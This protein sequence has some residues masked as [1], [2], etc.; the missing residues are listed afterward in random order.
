MKMDVA[1]CF[2]LCQS[3]YNVFTETVGLVHHSKLA[4][5]FLK[6]LYLPGRGG[7][8]NSRFWSLRTGRGAFCQKDSLIIDSFAL[9][10]GMLLGR[11]WFPHNQG[12]I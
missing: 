8:Y 6:V 1:D 9:A 4:L 12:Q 3:A 2:F 5:C 10:V 7:A 11:L